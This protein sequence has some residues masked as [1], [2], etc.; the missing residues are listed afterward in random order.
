MCQDFI[1]ILNV[2]EHIYPVRKKPH[3][4][5]GTFAHARISSPSLFIFFLKESCIQ[6]FKNSLNN[7]FHIQTRM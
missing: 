5:K 2:W 1:I 3:A 4:V 7:F 6:V